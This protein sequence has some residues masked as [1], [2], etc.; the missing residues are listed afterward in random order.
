[1][2][3]AF[4]IQGQRVGK[5]EELNTRHP[6]GD[7]P[8]GGGLLAIVKHFQGSEKWSLSQCDEGL[9]GCLKG[10]NIWREINWWARK[11]HREEVGGTRTP[12]RRDEI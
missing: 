5:E 8:Y 1:M 4:S 11:Y 12:S 6:E 7:F 10:E 2:E 9:I 3:G